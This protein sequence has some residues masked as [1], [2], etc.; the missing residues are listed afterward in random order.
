MFTNCGIKYIIAD[1]LN[2]FQSYYNIHV[3]VQFKIFLHAI[4]TIK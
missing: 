3:D 2:V 1:K 4:A